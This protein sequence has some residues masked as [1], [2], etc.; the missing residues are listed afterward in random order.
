MIQALHA[1]VSLVMEFLTARG[2]TGRLHTTAPLAQ[3][4]KME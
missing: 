2:T 3:F 4:I 1:D